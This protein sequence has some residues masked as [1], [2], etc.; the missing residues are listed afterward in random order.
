MV[1]PPS[2]KAPASL[3]F[4]QYHGLFVSPGT[5]AFAGSGEYVGSEYARSI[6][7]H[8]FEE[9]L[10]SSV[11]SPQYTTQSPAVK[12]VLSTAVWS[13]TGVSLSESES[14]VSSAGD[15]IKNQPF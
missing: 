9:L 12:T 2:S 3:S 6:F 4:F 1:F 15:T 10:V 11:P 13:A 5:F 7:V 14:V 8:D